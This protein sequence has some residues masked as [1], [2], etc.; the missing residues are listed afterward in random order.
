MGN[1]A[2]APRAIFGYHVAFMQIIDDVFTDDLDAVHGVEI[3]SND[4][5]GFLDGD[6][7]SLV[8]RVGDLQ[9]T[10]S[11][12]KGFPEQFAIATAQEL[13]T[14]HLMNLQVDFVIHVFSALNFLDGTH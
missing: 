13:L 3:F 14:V 2:N 4:L 6:F 8:K 1:A 12:G 9:A 10:F 7:R 5:T 11:F